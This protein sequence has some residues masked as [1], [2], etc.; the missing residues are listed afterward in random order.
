MQPEIQRPYSEVVWFQTEE[1]NPPAD[2]SQLHR[3][4]TAF[5]Y[6]L[7]QD[8]D[9][10]D[11]F[12]KLE[13]KAEEMDEMERMSATKAAVAKGVSEPP[14]LT[15]PLPTAI[16]LW[17]INPNGTVLGNLP[18]GAGWVGKSN[19]KYHFRDRN[20]ERLIGYFE[21]NTA[22]EKDETRITITG[23]REQDA[24]LEQNAP[25][26]KWAWFGFALTVIGFLAFIV[27]MGSAMETGGKLSDARNIVVSSATDIDLGF[28]HIVDG[29]CTDNQALCGDE[30]T[31]QI[32][33]KCRGE[34]APATLGQDKLLTPSNLC[35]RTWRAALVQADNKIAYRTDLQDVA[36]IV[37][38]FLTFF[39][40]SGKDLSKAS[41]V[42]VSEYVLVA[43]LSLIF[44][45][46]GIGLW[47]S[48]RVAGIVISAQNRVSLSMV[49]VT[50]WTIVILAAYAIFCAFNIGAIGGRSNAVGDSPS[51]FPL[52]E[53]WVWGVIGITIASPFASALIK[54]SKPKTGPEPEDQ[55]RSSST[56]LGAR[57]RPLSRNPFPNQASISDIFLGEDVANA[58]H[59]DISRTQNVVITAL[60][61]FTFIGWLVQITA[62]IGTP[63]ILGAFVTASPILSSFPEPG[64]TFTALLALTHGAYL[65][66]K[67]RQRS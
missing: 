9:A 32:V 8:K 62:S 61:L 21:R 56:T 3:F 33:L 58:S 39:H 24:S 36:D 64:P 57:L 19:A 55:S 18:K 63:V 26:S 28:A 20:G 10:T 14:N 22:L 23:T 52:L 6:L 66:G 67:L 48:G 45:F 53:G 43:M 13:L 51:L 41:F 54:E 12:P 40:Q 42:S 35:L 29:V 7:T 59:L 65:T 60:L 38:Y 47:I 11:A 37:A 17:P 30:T 2:G 46:G 15:E 27:S 5:A 44:I 4:Q 31:D 49:Q 1:L 25:S 16:A 50:A 34:L